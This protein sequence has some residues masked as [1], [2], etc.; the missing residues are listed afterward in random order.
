[1]CTHTRTHTQNYNYLHQQMATQ[2]NHV[3]MLT[4]VG[5]KEQRDVDCTFTESRSR[6]ASC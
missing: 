2:H 6:S 5:I 3:I 1:M 4:K